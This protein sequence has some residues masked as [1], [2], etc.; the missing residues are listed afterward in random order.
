MSKIWSEHLERQAL[1]YVRQSTLVQVRENL[2]SQARQYDLVR[3][4]L[5]LG[6]SQ[7]QIVVIDPAGTLLCGLVPAAG[8]LRPVPNPGGG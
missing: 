5:D 2:G 8:N 4:A 1:I 3:R 6:W 7:A